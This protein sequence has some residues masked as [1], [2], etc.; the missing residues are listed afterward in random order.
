M[1]LSGFYR[2]QQTSTMSSSQSEKRRQEQL[3]RKRQEVLA[4]YAS[5][6]EKLAAESEKDRTA[7]D[8]FVKVTE[9]MEER[10]KKSTVG[11]VHA[12][13]FQKIRAELEEENRRKAAQTNEVEKDD[14][15]RKK[16]KD[17]KSKILSFADDD[18]EQEE[19]SANGTNGVDKDG[20]ECKPHVTFKYEVATAGIPYFKQ[21]GSLKRRSLARTPL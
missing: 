11:L 12:E 7:A 15:K 4:D 3:E 2:P 10:L 13:D 5:Q 21:H 8:R 9:T 14:K 19:E 18:D 1:R 16:K 17:K 20:E 6:R